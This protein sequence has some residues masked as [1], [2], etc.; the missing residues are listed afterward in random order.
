M[1]EKKLEE[2]PKKYMFIDESGDLGFR[3]GSSKFLI[4][5]ALIVDNPKQLDRIIKNMRRYSFRKELVKTN[6][7]KA[8]KSSKKIKIHMLQK[9]NFV[10]GAKV[11]HLI[12]EKRKVN[13]SLFLNE[14]HILYNYLAGKLARNIL[15][16][17]VDFEI[18]IDKSKG[19]L[20][21]QKE[22]NKHF[23]KMLRI[24]CR[25][26][27]CKIEHRYSH[28]WSG[29]QFAD[30]LAWSC[31]RKFESNQEEYINQLNIEQ[32]FYQIWK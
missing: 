27:K 23:K 24:S 7:I 5:S 16:D 28:K 30:V 1:M 17:N 11:F 21:L 6:E 15:F 25:G 12:L 19:T 4:I 2:K 18:K 20:F 26:L 9:L 29:L 13:S 32:E 14:K 3:K 31:F 10:D 22:F 8:N